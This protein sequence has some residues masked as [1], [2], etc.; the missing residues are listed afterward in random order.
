M[1]H[2]TL[3]SAALAA[4]SFLL[5]SLLVW[6]PAAAELYVSS[7][8]LKA[9]L[10]VVP[11]LMPMYLLRKEIRICERYA[12]SQRLFNLSCF[13]GTVL[14]AIAFRLVLSSERMMEGLGKQGSGTDDPTLR[15]IW[16]FFC[17]GVAWIFLSRLIFGAVVEYFS[18]R[19]R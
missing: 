17:A 19:R 3:I 4:V 8:L 13:A 18:A 1:K 16:V 12:V 6:T 5:G 7:P 9:V 10:F 14:A 2:K 15:L 11:F